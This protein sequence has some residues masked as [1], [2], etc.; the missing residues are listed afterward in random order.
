MSTV[1]H[2]RVTV[3]SAVAVLAAIG[4]AW[5]LLT[6]GDTGGNGSTQHASSATQTRAEGAEPP[7]ADGAPCAQGRRISFDQFQSLDRAYPLVTPD[8]T[9]TKTLEDLTTA[10]TCPVDQSVILQYRGFLVR[11]EPGELIT[12]PSGG[13]EAYYDSMKTDGD[14]TPTQIGGY[15]GF[16]TRAGT[17]T[18]SEAES[19]GAQF[20]GDGVWI[21]VSAKNA[22]GA[23]GVT[24]AQQVA[25]E[26]ASQ[27]GSGTGIH[28]AGPSGVATRSS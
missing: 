16:V 3:V 24:A 28:K 12:D 17:A 8:D 15:P 20:V 27:V 22:T 4:L 10:W 7:D 6:T 11:E 13:A 23:G 2:P 9:A 18:D 5:A 26:L 14:G 1:R 19:E 21:L 25:E